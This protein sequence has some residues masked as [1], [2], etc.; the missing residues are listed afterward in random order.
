MFV[1]KL[2]AGCKDGRMCMGMEM[3]L[4]CHAVFLCLRC[5]EPGLVSF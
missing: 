5:P 4:S 1:K 2:A 3:P